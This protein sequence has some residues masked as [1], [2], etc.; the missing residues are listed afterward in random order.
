MPTYKIVASHTITSEH[1]AEV[2][3]VADSRPA[4][5]REARS[6]DE[7]GRLPWRE[8]SSIQENETDYAIS[9]VTHDEPAL[10]RR[11]LAT[12]LEAYSVPESVMAQIMGLIAKSA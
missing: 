10:L 2:E 7:Q 9:C 11:D 12:L 6:M 3:V 5:I 1:S 4:A 8:D